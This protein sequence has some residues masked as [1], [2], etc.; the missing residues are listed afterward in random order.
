M[1]PTGWLGLVDGVVAGGCNEMASKGERS[2]MSIQ[3]TGQ[4]QDDVVAYAK[5]R[6]PGS[7][8]SCRVDNDY[9]LYLL[10]DGNELSIKLDQSLEDAVGENTGFKRLDD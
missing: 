5:G 6:L 2:D 4:N 10:V 7:S 1:V 3:W 9:T 8:I